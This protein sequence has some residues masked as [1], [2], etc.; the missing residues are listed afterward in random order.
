MIS[1]CTPEI[2]GDAW[3]WCKTCSKLVSKKS[4]GW[5]PRMISVLASSFPMLWWSP[6][7]NHCLTQM[8]PWYPYIYISMMVG[9]ISK[10][11]QGIFKWHLWRNSSGSGWSTES[12]THWSGVRLKPQKTPLRRLRGKFIP[13]FRRLPTFKKKTAGFYTSDDIQQ[14]PGK[15]LCP[16]WYLIHPNTRNIFG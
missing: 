13:K 7:F 16:F 5:I 12:T 10:P 9:S 15:C 1:R 8:D 6:G 11:R 3:N 14:H 4:P 2:V